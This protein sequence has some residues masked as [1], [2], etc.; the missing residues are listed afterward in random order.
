MYH[1]LAVAL[2]SAACVLMLVHIVHVQML[3]A[4]RKRANR[5]KRAAKRVAKR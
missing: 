4:S 2:C 1:S 5:R 3:E